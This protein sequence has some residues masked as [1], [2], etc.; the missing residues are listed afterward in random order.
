M[1]DFDQVQDAGV[2][3]VDRARK[4]VVAGVSA[5]FSLGVAAFSASLTADGNVKTAT[6]AGALAFIGGLPVV[7]GLTYASKP[8]RRSRR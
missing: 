6:V 7:G 1:G 3:F 8:N 5:A 4:A 2:A